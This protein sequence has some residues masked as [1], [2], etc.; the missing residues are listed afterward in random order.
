MMNYF[1]TTNIETRPDDLVDKTITVIDADTNE[2]TGALKPVI[3]ELKLNKF[4]LK[5]IS[6]VEKV[7]PI[8]SNK[9]KLIQELKNFNI[10]GLK[11]TKIVK[12]VIKNHF[13]EELKKIHDK[14]FKNTLESRYDLENIKFIAN[15]YYKLDKQIAERKQYK[16]DIFELNKHFKQKK[17]LYFYN[18]D[19]ITGKI[20]SRLEDSVVYLKIAEKEAQLKK[21]ED[22]FEEIRAYEIMEIFEDM[23]KH[24]NDNYQKN[25]N[26]LETILM[27]ENNT[28]DEC[29]ENRD[30][31][32]DKIKKLEKY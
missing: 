26:K 11:K 15:E 31:M 2:L 4:N 21:I 17:L 20:K 14:M 7:V 30:E 1:W 10:G 18:Y 13:E 3:D 8:K 32:I 24:L 25:I 9:D 12:I 22:L 23:L 27:F 16:N 28:I 29:F 6:R 19:D 5:K